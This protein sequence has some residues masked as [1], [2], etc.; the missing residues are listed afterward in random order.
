MR[1]GEGDGVGIQ[2]AIK[3]SISFR[4]LGEYLK[5]EESGKLI[6]ELKVSP[7]PFLFLPKLGSGSQD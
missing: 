7:L 2:E 5:F 1:G 4:L 3:G 6:W